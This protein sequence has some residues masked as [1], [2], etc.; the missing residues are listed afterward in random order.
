MLKIFL[1]ILKS[2]S[3]AIV[4]IE[5]KNCTIAATIHIWEVL[6]KDLMEEKLVMMYMKIF[7]YHYNQTLGSPH[8]L[9]YLMD[10]HYTGINLNTCEETE[11]LLLAKENFL[12]LS[13]LS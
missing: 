8:F 10:P 11:Y 9:D 2:L 5:E 3:V 4:N 1:N 12:Y 6:E 7:S 13:C